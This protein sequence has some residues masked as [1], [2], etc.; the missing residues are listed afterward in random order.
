MAKEAL[1]LA[2]DYTDIQIFLGRLHMWGQNTESARMV[3]S[4][5][6]LNQTKTEDFFV[7]YATLEIQD[8]RLSDGLKLIEEG[9]ALYPESED[10]ENLKKRLRSNSYPQYPENN[11]VGIAYN[12]IRFNNQPEGNWH[13]LTLQ[14]QRLT[15]FGP[16][17]LKGNFVNKFDNKGAQVEIE[18]YPRLSPMFYLYVGAG[19]SDNDVVF[20]KFRS[21]LSLY[22]NLPFRLEGELGFR[23]LY[24][25]ENIMMYTASLGQYYEN[26]WY[27]IRAFIG[28]NQDRIS[29]S[30]AAN[31]RYYPKGALDYWGLQIG[32]GIEPDDSRPCSSQIVISQLI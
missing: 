31:V 23:Q 9:L 2:P 8:G 22:A 20:P 3:F 30:Y 28:P 12:Y 14:Y 16:V 24:F 32:T 4:D 27:N 17:I 18:A 25:T 21:G 19:Y 5:L 6:A 10:L 15:R 26:F 29:Q 13:M 1:Q 7:A 11:G